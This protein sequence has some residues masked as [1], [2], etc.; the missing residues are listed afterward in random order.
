L[1]VN[2]VLLPV[3]EL[4]QAGLHKAIDAALPEKPQS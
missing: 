1:F 2:T 3:S 4:N